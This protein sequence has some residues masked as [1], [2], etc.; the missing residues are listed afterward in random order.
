MCLTL[1]HLLA[2]SIVL[3][4]KIQNKQKK[5]FPDGYSFNY[6]HNLE[7][8]QGCGNVYQEP[9][10]FQNLFNK[11]L[12]CWL[13]FKSKIFCTNLKDKSLWLL[14]SIVVSRSIYILHY[15]RS[16][17]KVTSIYACCRQLVFISLFPFIFLCM[18]LSQLIFKKSGKYSFSYVFI[19][20]AKLK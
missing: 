7:P 19:C 5:K 20:T 15:A 14:P 12:R 18:K 6:S 2:N 17:C 3:P 16:F 10:F 1:L 11:K 9:P 4:E 13:K 8:M